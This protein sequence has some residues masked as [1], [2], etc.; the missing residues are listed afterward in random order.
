MKKIIVLILISI[1]FFGNAHAQLYG[2]SK[3]IGKFILFADTLRRNNQADYKIDQI[4][5]NK[6]TTRV[7]ALDN[8]N[9]AIC[10]SAKEETDSVFSYLFKSIAKFPA[11][12]TLILADSDFDYLHKLSGWAKVTSQIDS[13]LLTKSPGITQPKLAVELFHILIHNQHSRGFGLKR[14]DHSVINPDS[15]DLKRVEEII[16]EYGWPTYSMVGKAAADGAFL[17][18]QHSNTAVQKKYLNQLLDAAKKKEA[19]PGSVAMLQDRISAADCHKQIYGTQ[20]FQQMDKVTHKLSKFT[21]YPIIDEANVD[22]R[23]KEMGLM[24]LKEYLKLFGIDYVP[25]TAFSPPT[26]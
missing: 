6:D 9:L 8:Y 4:K 5:N 22:K 25:G 21:Y 10:Y 20:V 3:G 19:S 17:V 12:N 15:I 16:Q 24:P 14:L 1:S 11:A 23:R 13:L 7:K 2:M 18:I 26:F